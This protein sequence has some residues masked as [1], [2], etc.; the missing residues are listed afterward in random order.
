LQLGDGS[1]DTFV[2][3]C[4]TLDGNDLIT[5][6]RSMQIRAKTNVMLESFGG[7]VD[8]S[9]VEFVLANMSALKWSEELGNGLQFSGCSK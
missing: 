2:L 3:Q 8:N 7:Q 5:I 4:K 1:L 9:F 6:S